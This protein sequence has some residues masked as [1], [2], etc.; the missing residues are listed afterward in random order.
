M[1]IAY[2]IHHRRQWP[3]W[4]KDW[5]TT[6]DDI[7]CPECGAHTVETHEHITECL[8]CPWKDFNPVAALNDEA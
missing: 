4:A 1:T 2:N 6:G 7:A 8:S 3:A 5:E